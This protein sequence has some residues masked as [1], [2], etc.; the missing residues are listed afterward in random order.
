[1]APPLQYASVSFG[2][3]LAFGLRA[4]SDPVPDVSITTVSPYRE[5]RFC[6]QNCLWGEDVHTLDVGRFLECPPPVA[7]SCWCNDGLASSASSF[8]TSC[9]NQFCSSAPGDVSRAVSVYNGYCRSIAPATN[10]A[11]PTI[12]SKAPTST[13]SAFVTVLSSS[14]PTSGA[15]SQAPSESLQDFILIETTLCLLFFGLHWS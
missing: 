12:D 3:I 14:T 13:V 1:M 10:E 2:I 11:T 8:L 15:A 9:V 4:L 7:N 6:A 5:Q